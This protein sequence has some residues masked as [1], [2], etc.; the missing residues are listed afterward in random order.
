MNIFILVLFLFIS[1]IHLLAC[2]RLNNKLRFFT[3]PL[4]IP[5]LLLFAIFS[6]SKVSMTLCSALI[7]GFLGDV[8]LLSDNNK[9]FFI[10][11]LLSFLIGHAFYVVSLYNKTIYYPS[12]NIIILII[13]TLSIISIAAYYSIFQYLQDMKFPVLIYFIT[14]SSM[15]IYSILF[16]VSSKNIQGLLALIGS[17]LFGLSD[18]ILA[19]SIFI[20]SFKLK[21]FIV[22][23]TYLIAQLLLTVSL[24]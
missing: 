11:G 12:L 7:F 20:K 17:S 2:I 9:S 18:Y 24:I 13:L 4:L 8:F 5:L 19:R 21:N 23:L 22:M 3:K 16:L 6:S 14:I 15:I 10:L 1:L